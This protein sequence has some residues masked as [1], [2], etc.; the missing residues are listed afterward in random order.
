[1]FAAFGAVSFAQPHATDCGRTLDV[2]RI[3]KEE[4]KKTN[5]TILETFEKSINMTMNP[6]CIFPTEGWNNIIGD[7]RRYELK[8]Y[9]WTYA[10][11]FMSLQDAQMDASTSG[12]TIRM[13][14]AIIVNLW[15]KSMQLL[16]IPPEFFDDRRDDRF[17]VRVKASLRPFYEIDDENA[18]LLCAVFDI[19][20]VVEFIKLYYR[21]LV[22]ISLTHQKFRCFIGNLERALK[23]WAEL[24]LDQPDFFF[25]RII[26]PK[27]DLTRFDCYLFSLF[28]KYRS[29]I[30]SDDPELIQQAVDVQK[31]IVTLVAEGEQSYQPRKWLFWMLL[32]I[33]VVVVVFFAILIIRDIF[34]SSE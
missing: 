28:S 23:K 25:K 21:D 11:V 9:L 18:K 14:V 26:N 8:D 27:A 1:M 20:H 10:R 30:T 7:M 16:D 5:P 15:L 17:E 2:Q 4:L 29:L 33:A 12:Y 19:K 22:R 13:A 6:W 3:I 34:F 24:C 31:D 32:G